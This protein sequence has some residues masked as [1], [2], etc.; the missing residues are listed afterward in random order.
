MNAE[1]MARLPARS[2]LSAIRGSNGVWQTARRTID[3]E[4]PVVMGILNVTPDSFS[5]GGLF[6][7]PEAAKRRLRELSEGGADM[8]DIGGESTRPGASPVSVDEELSRV[9]P[10]LE[11]AVGLDI[12]VSID[13]AKSEVA[14]AA[15]DAGAEIIN[16]ISG[17]RFDPALAEVVAERRAGLVLMHIRGE[18]RTM[19][20][21][22]YY[23]DLLGDISAE[24]ADSIEVARAAGCEPE[25]L[26]VDPGI[27]FGKTAEQNLELIARMDRFLDL[28]YPVLFGASRKSFI[29]ATLD[30]PLGE[31]V[32]AT[33]AACV[34][35]MVRGARIFRVHDV[36][37]ARRALDMA[38]L[39]LGKQ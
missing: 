9:M 36:K 5:D 3:L 12:P 31:R 6:Q 30:L 13:T 34:I 18:P 21:G 7:E 29:G 35:G 32:E 11:A 37:Q 28:G 4:R 25:T 2:P 15:L 14:K 23:D 33:L 26:V 38:D 19:Q 27:G 8:I 24:L 39:I 16:D 10:V 20:Q 1:R 22:I 17:L